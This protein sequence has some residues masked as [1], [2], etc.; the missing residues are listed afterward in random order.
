MTAVD[1]NVLLRRLLN[2]DAT[3]AEKARRLLETQDGYRCGIGK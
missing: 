2:D 3:Q 1:A